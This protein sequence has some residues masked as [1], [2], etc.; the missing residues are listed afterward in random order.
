MSEISAQMVKELREKTGAGMMDCKKALA[1]SAGDMEKAIQELRK[2]GLKSVEKRSDKVAAEGMVYS[3]IHP[4]NRVG[5][6]LEMNCET[7]FVARGEQFVSLVRDIA[8]HIAWSKPRF[9]AREEISADV[10]AKEEE[11]Y[12]AQLK[13]EQA[14]VADKIIS[15]KVD[16]FFEEVCLLEQFDIKDSGSKKRIRDL[17]IDLSASVGEKIEIRRFQRFEVGEGI[18]KAKTDYAAE[19]AAVAQ[20]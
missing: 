15:G 17:L 13:P 19:V 12:R 11:V 9:V 6:L 7:D 5:V 20:M 4:G 1:E 14:K 8:M 18:E 3:Y 2:K 10:I 16:K